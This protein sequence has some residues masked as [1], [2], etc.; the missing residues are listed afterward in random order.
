MKIILIFFFLVAC[1]PL[2]KIKNVTTEKIDFNKKMSFD[3][4]KKNLVRYN[5]ISNFPD[6]SK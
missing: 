3:E 1:V 4:Y 5:K 6:I 2:N